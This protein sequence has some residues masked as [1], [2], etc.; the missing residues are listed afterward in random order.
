MEQSPKDWVR[1]PRVT[2]AWSQSSRQDSAILGTHRSRGSP[3]PAAQPSRCAVELDLRRP[4]RGLIVKLGRYRGVAVL[5]GLRPSVLDSWFSLIYGDQAGGPSCR[6]DFACRLSSGWHR[7]REVGTFRRG[8][9]LTNAGR[10][11]H[12]LLQIERCDL[13]NGGL[14]RSWDP[15]TKDP[16]G[17]LPVSGRA[18]KI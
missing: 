7:T 3:G 2:M 14:E 15:L 17:I 9:P 13:L 6:A 4:I 11:P 18:Q 12:R 1:Q 8:E 16:G 10:A 5:Y